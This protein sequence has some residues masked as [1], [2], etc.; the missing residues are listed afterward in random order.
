M[1]VAGTAVGAIAVGEGT[2]V[3]GLGLGI[4]TRAEIA[5]GWPVGVAPIAVVATEVAE[6]RT[7]PIGLPAANDS[8]CR[9]RYIL[10]PTIIAK[11][12]KAMTTLGSRGGRWRRGETDRP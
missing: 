8:Y 6:G 9:Y 2:G 3:A 10:R 7:C 11:V 1:E 12:A 5:V 4:S